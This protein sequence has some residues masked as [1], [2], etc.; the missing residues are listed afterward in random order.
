MEEHANI[1]RRFGQ[2]LRELR[3]ERGLSQ[4]EFA[5]RAG[6]NR[7]YVS[8]VE[9]GVRNISLQNIDVVAKTLGLTVSELMQ[10][11]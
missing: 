8:D 2:R 3:K 5:A 10:G 4:E 1:V 6:L 11:V 7:S 9:R